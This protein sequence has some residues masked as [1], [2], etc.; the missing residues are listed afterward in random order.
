MQGTILIIRAELNM[1]S[2]GMSYINVRLQAPETDLYIRVHPNTADLCVIRDLA[3]PVCAAAVMAAPPKR[4]Y[5][6]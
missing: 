2:R 3:I 4:T 5:H 1:A 6:H